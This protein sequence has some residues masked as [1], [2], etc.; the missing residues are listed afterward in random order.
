MLKIIG[1][2]FSGLSRLNFCGHSVP[3]CGEWIGP[4]IHA[5]S[6]TTGYIGNENGIDLV[7]VII[8]A[9]HGYPLGARGHR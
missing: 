7:W 1:K 2:F 9:L 8:A 4:Y 5:E 6:P 3:P